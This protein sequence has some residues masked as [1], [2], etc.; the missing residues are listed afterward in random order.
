MAAL[1]KN[2]KEILNDRYLLRD[3]N[4]IV[5][6]TPNQMFKRVSLFLASSEINNKSY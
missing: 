4:A 1:R 6:E 3:R 2:A 5:I